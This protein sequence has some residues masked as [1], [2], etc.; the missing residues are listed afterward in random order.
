MIAL[1]Q[2]QGSFADALT[3]ALGARAGRSST[4]I[5]DRKASSGRLDRVDQI[6]AI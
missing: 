5:F 6:G 2:G 1:K 4:L 3:A